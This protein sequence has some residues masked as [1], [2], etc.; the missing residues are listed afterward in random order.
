MANTNNTAQPSNLPE[1]LRAQVKP[2]QGGVELTLISPKMMCAVI[3]EEG[4]IDIICKA[5]V[6]ARQKIPKIV[7][8]G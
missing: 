8:P 3:I 6:D 7:L 5:L 2:V 1:P 4:A